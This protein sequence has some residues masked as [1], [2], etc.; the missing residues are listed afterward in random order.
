MIWHQYRFWKQ[1]SGSEVIFSWAFFFSVCLLTKLHPDFSPLIWLL[2]S[3][4]LGVCDRRISLGCGYIQLSPFGNGFLPSTAGFEMVAD[5][6]ELIHFVTYIGVWQRVGFCPLFRLSL[7]NKNTGRVFLVLQLQ[8][9][10]CS[11]SDPL[12]RCLTFCCRVFHCSKE[13][14][15]KIHSPL[16]CEG[17]VP[18]HW[19][20]SDGGQ[21]GSVSHHTSL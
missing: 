12:W 17:F 2:W 10:C 15:E 3:L 11:V 4:G 13:K 19:L 14:G 6:W 8:S 1:E 18:C 20:L 7:C 16:K 9:S 5:M 21:R